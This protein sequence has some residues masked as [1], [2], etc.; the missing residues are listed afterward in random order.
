MS[1]HST[2]SPPRSKLSS[3][4]ALL[5]TQLATVTMP[6]IQP[7]SRAAVLLDLETATGIHRRNLYA[8]SRRLR[9]LLGPRR[10]PHQWLMEAGW[11]S[12]AGER[13]P[14]GAPRPDFAPAGVLETLI[15]GF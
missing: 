1:K 12:E 6:S 13:L 2:G 8:L 11:M 10:E 14:G 9:T 7:R 3:R 4:A 15:D 5:A